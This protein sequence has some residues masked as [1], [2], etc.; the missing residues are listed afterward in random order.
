MAAPSAANAAF[1]GANGIVVF[2]SSRV[3]AARWCHTPR[4]GNQLFEVLPG[5]SDALQ[6]TCT[7]GSDLHPFVSPDGSEVVFSN[8]VRGGRSRL[9]TLLL[10]STPQ[11]RPNPPTPVAD[12]PDASDDY[13]A[14]SPAGIGTIVFQRS[15]P[16]AP[17]QLY[18]E[19]VSD[20]SSAAPVFPSP[21]GFDD[22]EPVFD[23][24]D[25]DVVT[26]VRTI[27]DHMHI[28]SYNLESLMLTDLSARG[29]HGVSGN[30]SKPDYA[31]TGT[32]GRIVFQS[33][34]QCNRMQLYTMTSQ[35]TDQVPVF[36][37][38][39]HHFGRSTPRCNGASVDP[40][41]SPEGDALAYDGSRTGGATELFTV[42]VN[43]SGVATG[44]PTGIT[45]HCALTEEPNWG[46][47]PYPPAQTPEAGLPVAFPLIGAGILVGSLGI[48][49]RRR[50]R[51]STMR[52]GSGGADHDTP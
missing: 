6:L 32:G 23:P 45:N 49:R 43:S 34:R 27:G 42:A 52:R 16:G 18:V 38:G 35:G 9:F 30:D 14:W 19:K 46:P 11:S 21:T 28:V 20:P 51:R 50:D 3:G 8:T 26:F 15:T 7:T 44:S 40:V 39:E 29:D 10:P 13:P 47:A 31:A 25:P 4:T 37:P 41:F 12:P 22:G 2:A 36:P 48:Y 24:S 33:D 5:Q 1:P 17:T